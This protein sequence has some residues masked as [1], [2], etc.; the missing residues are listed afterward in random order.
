MGSFASCQLSSR[1]ALLAQAGHQSSSL[2][3]DVC[4]RP[5]VAVALL[6][7]VAFARQTATA[8]PAAL[9]VVFNCIL[10]VGGKGGAFCSSGDSGAGLA[11]LIDESDGSA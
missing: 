11:G 2:H 8:P 4:N 10:W 3:Q 9:A 1:C 5:S 7:R 6:S